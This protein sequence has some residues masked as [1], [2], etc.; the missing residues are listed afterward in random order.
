MA[1]SPVTAK[2]CN[3]CQAV[4]IASAFAKDPT[5]SD[6][7]TSI[8]R[9]CRNAAARARYQPKGRPAQS[10]PAP[11][12]PRDGDKLQARH[13]IN[14][15]VAAGRRAHPNSL[16]CADCGHIWIEGERRHEYDHHLGYAAEHHLA[17]EPVCTLCHHKRDNPRASQ[18]ACAK[19]HEFT[20]ENTF[21]PKE[22]GRAC[23]Q[24]R[25][26]YDRTRTRPPGY[27]K[28]VNDRRRQR[29]CRDDARPEV[30][31]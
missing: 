23:R 27:W 26:D 28:T 11:L 17:V 19:G 18:T 12:A 20:P 10:G 2:A 9:D 5:H 21:H 4:K 14:V 31:S 30:R 1:D 6:G 25:R 22:G 7:L 8:C 29:R 13:R 15:E 24:C 16:P 3:Q